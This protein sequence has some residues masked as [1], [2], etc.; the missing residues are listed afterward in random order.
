MGAAILLTRHALGRCVPLSDY[1]YELPHSFIAQEGVEP[2]EDAQLMVL[3]ADGGVAHSHI[4]DLPRLLGRGDVLVLNESRVLSARVRCR[5]PTGGR[6]ELLFLGAGAT[7]PGGDGREAECL[8]GGKGLR[9]GSVLVLGLGEE[10][11]EAELRKSIGEGRFIV[12][13]PEGATAMSVMRRWGEMPTPPYIRSRLRDQ[14]RYQT[15]FARV[16]GSVA[17]PTAGLHFTP[18][19]FEALA[20]RG[21]EVV[22][23]VLHVGVGTFKP[24]RAERVE[25]HRMDA[26]RATVGADVAGTL[27]GAMGDGRR[28]FAVGTTTVRTLET[29]TGPDGRV[30]PFDGMTGLFIHPPYR[31]RFPYS[32][33]LTN[34]HLPRSTLLM[35]VSAYAGRERVLGA[36]EDAK[37]LG[38]RF[39]SLGDAM[40]FQGGPVG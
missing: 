27:N 20:A 25:D 21:V 32:G 18:P 12:G 3:G 28:V 2:R 30:R 26:E 22:K 33:L 38:Y 8:V 35:L 5:K 31:F 9:E 37:R 7:P 16:D 14:A 13:L 24:V 6:V 11:V 1:D 40:L 19:L 15:T 36:Y 4:R 10:A 23:L 39:Y 34:F 17:A 29:A